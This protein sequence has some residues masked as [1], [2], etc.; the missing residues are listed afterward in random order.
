MA[1]AQSH[2][3]LPEP[4]HWPII[5]S[6]GL[7]TLV[8]GFAAF[9][10]GSSV[11]G[12]LMIIGAA[13][14]VFMMVGWFG[15]VIRESEKGIYNTQV[16]RSFRWSMGWFIFSEVMFFAAFFG[17]LFYARIYAVPWLGGEGDGV[18]TNA[19]LWPN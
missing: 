16:D 7:T 17:A 10:N 15:T 11:G 1:D 9:L 5:G 8:G 19:L 6:I 18:V 12:T 3:Y 13:I 14:V 4:T 2:Y